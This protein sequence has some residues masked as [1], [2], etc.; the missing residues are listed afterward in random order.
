MLILSRRV[1]QII[2]IGDD[3]TVTVL[4]FQGG[5]VRLGITAPKTIRVMRQEV[6]ERDRLTKG[7]R[8]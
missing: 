4:G 5:Q 8:P 2:N 6:I 7:T 3:V 1:G